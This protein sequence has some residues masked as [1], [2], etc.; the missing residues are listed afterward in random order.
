MTSKQERLEEMRQQYR[1][2]MITI[3]ELQA[4]INKEYP[5]IVTAKEV[6]EKCP[7]WKEIQDF[8]DHWYVEWT[9]SGEIIH[10][11]TDECHSVTNPNDLLFNDNG[12]MH[13]GLCVERWAVDHGA[14]WHYDI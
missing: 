10:H 6:K 7:D 12:D 9:C 5:A 11:Y 2:G 8:E 4:F 1:D 14:P 13:C 3:N